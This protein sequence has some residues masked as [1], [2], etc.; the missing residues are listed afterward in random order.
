ME[1]EARRKAAVPPPPNK[2]RRTD[3]DEDDLK[4]PMT[5]RGMDALTRFIFSWIRENR[6][7]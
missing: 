3:C 7:R 4:N 2:K 5:Y 1:V 6:L